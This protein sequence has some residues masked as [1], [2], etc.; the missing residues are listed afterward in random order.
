M[1]RVP[2]GLG[3]GGKSPAVAPAQAGGTNSGR[4]WELG[5]AARTPTVQTLFGEFE[6]LE[7]KTNLKPLS[8]RDPN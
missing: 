1:L 3:L 8:Q 6:V 4:S 7:N 2:R 5:I